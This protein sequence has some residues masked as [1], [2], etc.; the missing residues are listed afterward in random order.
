MVSG[1]YITLAMLSNT[2][3]GATPGRNTP[4]LQPLPAH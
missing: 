1:V 3:E 2:A 4:P